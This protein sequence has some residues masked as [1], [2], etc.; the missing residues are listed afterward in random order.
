MSGEILYDDGVP[1]Q[2]GTDEAV[3]SYDQH[4]NT[5]R[6]SVEEYTLSHNQATVRYHD[7]LADN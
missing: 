2:P 1:P 5:S 4:S 3:Y 7:Y 6:S